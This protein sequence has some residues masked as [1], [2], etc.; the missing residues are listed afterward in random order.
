M[1]RNRIIYA[2]QSV[3][4]NGEVLYRVQSLGSTTTFT[5][6][7]IFELGHLDIVDVVDDVPAVAVTLNT[8][9]FGDVRTLAVLAQIHPSKRDMDA[10]ATSSNANLVVVSGTDYTPTSTYL[11]G[12]ALADFAVVC[13]NLP[14]VTLWAPVQDECSLG[15]LDDNIDQTLFLDELY[16]NSLEFGYTTGANATENYGAETDIKCWFLNAGR[17]V[18]FDAFTLDG[19]D[20]AAGY[21][22]LTIA[23]GTAIAD[24]TM[25]TPGFV[26]KSDDGAPAATWYDDD[27]NEVTNIEVV[28]GTVAAADTFVY[29]GPS[30][31]GEHRLHFPIG[32]FA[33]GDRVEAIYS[34]NGYGTGTSDKYFETLDDPD[35]PDMLGAIRQG[36]VEIYI[37]DPAVAAYE[38]AWRLTGCTITADLTREALA[39]LG[40]LGPYDRPLT[41]PI[42]ITV[43]VDSTAGDLENWARFAGQK[44]GFD[45]DSL[46]DLCLADLMGE[47]DLKLVVKIFAQTDEEAGGTGANRTVAAGSPL[48]GKT[49]MSDGVELSAYIA[50][51]TELPLKTIVVEHLKITDEG[52]TLD[53]GANMTQTFGFRSTNDLY[54][55]KGELSINHISGDFTVR[56]NG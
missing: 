9:D 52:A 32:M 30:I 1:A 50:G 55:V 20:I 4:C 44:A 33:V 18:N 28:P 6:E 23:S 41:L 7:D 47:E 27:Q 48:V 45:N 25:A 14:G 10:N 16:I 26:R 34:A 56:R 3:W 21:V 31:T 54:V 39:E 53:M 19:A 11:H 8:N 37:V 42:P 43:T 2:S 15:T 36:Q 38:N 51:D 13:G 35:R 24:L 12:V 22:V 49:R 40:H 5:S 17:F 29:D 46:E